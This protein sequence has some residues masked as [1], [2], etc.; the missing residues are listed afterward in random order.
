MNKCDRSQCAGPHAQQMS[1]QTSKKYP[2]L[3]NWKSEFMDRQKM[4]WASVPSKWVYGCWKI[5]SSLFF[6]PLGDFFGGCLGHR[7]ALTHYRCHGGIVTRPETWHFKFK[8][9]INMD[10]MAS[11][12][13]GSV[14]ATF[15]CRWP[16]LQ[17]LRGYIRHNVR[18]NLSASG[19]KGCGRCL[20]RQRYWLL[21]FDMPLMAYVASRSSWAALSL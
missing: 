19:S 18:G 6:W 15:K 4:W 1:L 20:R 16:G 10:D 12:C 5:Y 2:A 3:M 14:D 7:Q 9:V 8:C 13:S 11:M 21:P 17:G